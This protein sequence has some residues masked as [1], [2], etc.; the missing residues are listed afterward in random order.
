MSER[1][2]KNLRKDFYDSITN[3]DI[4]FFDERRTGDLVSRLNSDIQ[5]V[6]DTLSTNVSMFVRGMMF[7]IIVLCILM[8]LSPPL[9]GMTFAGII[10]LIVFARFYSGW[11]RTLQR[12]IQA[13]KGKMNTVAEENFSNIRT[14]KAFSN[15]LNEVAKFDSI[16]DVVY[17]FGVKKAK[18]QAI[19][20]FIT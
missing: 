19:F 10:P 9:T 13:E 7:I 6:Q 14:V 12:T 4:A 8:V 17:D 11:M 1:I 3:K 5:V 18:Y 15:E 2:A 16:N 20:A